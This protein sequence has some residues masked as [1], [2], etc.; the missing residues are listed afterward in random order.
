MID[1][2]VYILTLVAAVGS[3]VVAG[4]F[5]VFSVMVMRA[6]RQLPPAQ[7]LA[8]MQ[9]INVAAVRPIF[10]TAL[11]LPALACVVL[12]ITALIRWGESGFALVLAGSAAYL[13][14]S[15]ALTIAFHVPRN[16]ALATVEPGSPDMEAR[17]TRFAASWTAGNHVRTIASLLAA[18][19]LTIALTR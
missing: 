9:A 5:L 15:I 8:A 19:L 7:G 18:V 4:A 1:G 17:W 10:M 12:V 2:Y 16:D 6:L 3:G 11:F 13:V 14:G